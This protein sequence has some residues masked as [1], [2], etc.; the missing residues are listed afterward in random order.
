[1]TP[2]QIYSRIM[3]SNLV[4]SHMILGNGDKALQ[5]TERL[6]VLEQANVSAQGIEATAAVEKP[7]G[8]RGKALPH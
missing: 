5:R 1:M 7:K 8:W 4:N 2:V 6:R 3:P